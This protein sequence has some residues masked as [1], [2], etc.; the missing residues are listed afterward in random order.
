MRHLI[1]VLV[2]FVGIFAKPTPDFFDF[3]KGL[4]GGI[5]GVSN[6]LNDGIQ[7]VAKGLE[8][9]LHGAS[10]NIKQGNTFGAITSALGGTA[11]VAGGLLSGVTGII[12]GA[13]NGFTRPLDLITTTQPPFQRAIKG[14]NDGLAFIPGYK[15]SIYNFV[16]NALTG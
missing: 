4:I 14:I 9:G 16:L 15:N 7:N 10:T 2:A 3:A 12:G 13:W 6:G 1:L 8:S 11:G 5:A